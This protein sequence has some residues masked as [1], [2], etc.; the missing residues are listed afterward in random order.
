MNRVDGAL[1]V[2]GRAKFSAE[3]ETPQVAYAVIVQSTIANGRIARMET[4]NAERA[5]GVLGI[6]SPKNAS[7]LPGAE[8]RISVLQDDRI[9]YNNQPIAVVVADSHE[10]AWHAA[11]LIRVRYSTEPA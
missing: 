11:T 8:T 6:L 4:H 2:T 9:S 5:A 10:Q 3:F 1:K 7:K